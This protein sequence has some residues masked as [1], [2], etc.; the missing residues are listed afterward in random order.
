[1]CF[2]DDTM[3]SYIFYYACMHAGNLWTNPYCQSS[4]LGLSAAHPT[5]ELTVRRS[6]RADHNSSICSSG[7]A[8][9]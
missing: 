1:M 6:G 3:C 4:D 8:L 7:I 2:P 5:S 9:K